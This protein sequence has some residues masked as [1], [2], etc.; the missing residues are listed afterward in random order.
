MQSYR[1]PD[2]DGLLGRGRQVFEHFT[3]DASVL[4]ME[5]L[6]MWQRQFR[7]MKEKVAR[8]SWYGGALDADLLESVK[9][10]IAEEGPSYVRQ[11]RIVADGGDLPGVV[12]ALRSELADSIAAEV[13]GT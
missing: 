2:L 10:R 13:A 7:R 5:F 4:P 11:R 8:S 1:E 9:R 12:R 6:P 3:H